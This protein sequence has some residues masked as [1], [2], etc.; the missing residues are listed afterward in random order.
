[1][2]SVDAVSLVFGWSRKWCVGKSDAAH[3]GD[4]SGPSLESDERTRSEG[5]LESQWRPSMTCVQAHG[6]F[7]AAR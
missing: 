6:C 4:L 1:M 5:C 7:A 3:V 2:V